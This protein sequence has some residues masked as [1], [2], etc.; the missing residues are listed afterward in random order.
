[1]SAPSSHRFARLLLAAAVFAAGC[2]HVRLDDGGSWEEGVDGD[3]ARVVAHHLASF[4]AGELPERAQ[5]ELDATPAEGPVGAALAGSLTSHGFA[6]AS[7][8]AAHRLRYRVS[9]VLGGVVVRLSLDWRLEATRFF[10]RGP[11]GLVA[12]AP[13]GVGRWR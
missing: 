11:D 9:P 1:M 10:R 6:L 4:L 5:V 3:E 12:Q 13:W 2:S 8:G 7:G